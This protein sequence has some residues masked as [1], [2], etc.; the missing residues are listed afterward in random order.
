MI[1]IFENMIKFSIYDDDIDGGFMFSRIQNYVLIL[2]RTQRYADEHQPK[3]KHITNL[4][5]LNLVIT[6]LYFQ[7]EKLFIIHKKPITE[8]MAMKYCL[9]E[10]ISFY[11]QIK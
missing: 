7:H 4:V 9:G 11:Y 6:V 1:F 10:K 8:E 5:E 3:K 2:T